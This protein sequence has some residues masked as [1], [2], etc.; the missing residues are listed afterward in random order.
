MIWSLHPNED[1]KVKPS[2]QLTG[3]ELRKIKDWVAVTVIY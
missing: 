3:T 2:D 1:N